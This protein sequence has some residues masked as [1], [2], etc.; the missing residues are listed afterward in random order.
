[1]DDGI[2]KAK[3]DALHGFIKAAETDILKDRARRR[4]TEAS[5]ELK[6]MWCCDMAANLIHENDILDVEQLRDLVIEE[7]NKPRTIYLENM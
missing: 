6:L 7:L 4:A 3:F 2:W 1:L 5:M